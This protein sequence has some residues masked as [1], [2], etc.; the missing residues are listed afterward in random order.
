MTIPQSSRIDA[1]AIG[2]AHERIRD[3][4]RRTPILTI[5]AGELG[6]TAS[7]TL[8]LEL[9]QHSGSF[10][11][12]GAFNSALA[13]GSA[14]P[15][16]LAASGGNHGL[17]VAY[18]ARE[19]GVPAEIFVPGVSSPLKRDRISALG[20]TVHVIGEL[21]DDAQSACDERAASSDA[22]YIHPFNQP[23]TVAGQATVGVEIIEQA[24]DVQTVLV[25]L[26]GGGL[27]SGIAAALPRSV[28]V[29]TVEPDGSRCFRAAVEAGRPVEVPV[30]GVAADSLGAREVGSLAWS[31]LAGRAESLT[32]TDDAIMAARRQLWAD[33]RIVAEPG[34]ATALAALT[35]GAYSPA[36]GERVV[37]VVCGGNTDPSDLI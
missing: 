7:A 4:V 12:R 5:G 13:S 28:R 21:Y 19:L 18:V 16:L 6:L 32:V 27:A 25:A 24:P 17:A 22:L 34:G 3:R 35:S 9:L 15:G 26:G 11:V 37:V 30:S 2:T 31:I 29:V 20:A 14:E 1:G 10:K 8:K 23:H 33:A 36:G